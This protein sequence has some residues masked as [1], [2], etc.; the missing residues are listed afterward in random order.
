MVTGHRSTLEKKRVEKR[1]P[2]S[3][4]GGE[5]RLV[6]IESVDVHQQF[7]KSWKDI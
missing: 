1:D 5:W 2:L 4:D 6:M 3:T 7:L